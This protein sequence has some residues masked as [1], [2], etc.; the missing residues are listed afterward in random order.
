VLSDE[1]EAADGAQR[2]AVIGTETCNIPRLGGGRWATSR[3]L[4]SLAYR[5]VQSPSEGDALLC[6][7]TG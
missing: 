3:L 4:A 1:S 6:F 2:S 5:A 7:A